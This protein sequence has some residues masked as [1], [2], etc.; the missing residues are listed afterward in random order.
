MKQYAKLLR[1]K[2]YVKN[3]LVFVPMFF[4]GSFFEP[5]K[6]LS[7]LV[8]FLAFSLTCSAVYIF[9]DLRD[10][11]KDRAHPTKCMRPIPERYL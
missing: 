5:S 6:F 10:A 9:N 1:I 7:A 3:I 2:H 4:N 11:E 8:G